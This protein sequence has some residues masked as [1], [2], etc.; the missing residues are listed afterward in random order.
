MSD[1]NKLYGLGRLI[2]VADKGLNSSKNID[3][4]VNNGDGYVV[5]QVLRGNK[6]QRYH[7]KLFDKDGYVFSKDGTY[8]YKLY[9]E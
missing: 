2:V 6:G 4:I 1:I 5:S 3:E 9:E 7:A 8:K